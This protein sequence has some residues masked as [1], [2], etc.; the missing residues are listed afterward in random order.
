MF[1][2]PHNAKVYLSVTS[3]DFR[4]QI[5]GLKKWIRNEMQQ[6]PL[7]EAYFF[8][9]SKNKKA[10]KVLH[11][12]RQGCCLYHKQL[13]AG[14]FKWWNSLYDSSLNYLEIRPIE[15]QVILRNGSINQLQAQKNW[16]SSE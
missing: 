5:Q 16:R 2:I 8:F 14:K 4:K 13:S 9:I 3:V 1:N 12:D 6:D 15:S 10:I 11:Y 7:S